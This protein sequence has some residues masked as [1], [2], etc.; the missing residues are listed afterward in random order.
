MVDWDA[1]GRV[2]SI[3]ESLHPQEKAGGQPSRVKRATN[4]LPLR[5]RSHLDSRAGLYRAIST[6]D[7]RDA[8]IHRVACGGTRAALTRAVL[9]AVVK[10]T[11]SYTCTY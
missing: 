11:H 5:R 1:T 10:H 9:I 7:E 3:T 8:N 2:G 6:A 4:E